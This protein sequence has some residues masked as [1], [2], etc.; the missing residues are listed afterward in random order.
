LFNAKYRMPYG[1]LIRREYINSPAEI[2]Y[3]I[4]KRFEIIEMRYFPLSIP[5]VNLNLC[6]GLTARKPAYEKIDV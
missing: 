6:I 5:L 3:V 2:L 4:K 1:W